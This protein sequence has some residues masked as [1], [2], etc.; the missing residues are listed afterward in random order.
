[1]LFANF[2]Y[3]QITNQLQNGGFEN[4]QSPWSGWSGNIQLTDANPYAGNY[5]ARFL[6]SGTLEQ[7]PVTVETGKTYKMSV[8][9]R[10]NSMSGNDW[11]GIRFSA[12]EYNWSEWHSSEFFTNGNRPVGQ[13][14]QEIITF[15]PSTTQIRAQIG[16]FG[17]SG[18]VPDFSFDEVFLFEEVVANEPP[19]IESFTLNTSSGTVPFTVTGEIVA[20]D[21]DGAITNYIIETGDGAVYAG[22]ATFSHVYRI[23]G[24]YSLLVTVVDDNGATATTS[25]AITAI[26]TNNHSIIITQPIA[27]T[28]GIYNTSQNT[29]T[30]EGNRQNGTG[31]IF[32]LNNR[33]MQSGFATVTSNSFIIPDMLLEVGI[34]HIQVQS[35]RSDGNFVTDDIHVNYVPESFNG[36]QIANL[37]VS[38]TAVKQYER[39]DVTFSLQTIADNLFFPF[40]TL[41][42]NNLQSGSG[43]SVDMEFSNGAI[44]KVQPAFLNMDYSRENGQ[45]LPTGSY[46]WNVR[47]AFKETGTW[48][49]RIIAR[50]ASGVT[51]LAGP[52]FNVVP[53]TS[54]NG[55][56]RVS[57]NDNRYFEYDN[58]KPFFAMG[59]GTSASGPDE[60]DQEITVWHENGLNFGR[61]WLSSSAPF[62][63]PWS[64][65]ATHH[66]MENN[67]YMPPPLLTFNQKYGNGQFS[68]RIASP[69][70]ENQNTPAIFRGFWDGPATVEPLSAY[71]LI[72]RVKTVNVSGN[73]GLVLK[74]GGWLGTD[75]INPGVG[76]VLT[77][78]MKGDNQWSYL[79]GQI[80][81][82]PGQTTLGYIYLVLEDCTGEAFIEQLTLQKINPDGSL[83]QNILPKWNA[84]SHYYL[85]P[86]KSKNID[87]MID[88]ANR[89]GIHY[90]IVIHEKNDF[91]SNHID[92]FGYVSSSQGNFN[93]P[94]G[95]KLHRIYEYYWRHLV[96]RWGYATAVHS[97]E[98]V[99]EGAPASYFE[100]TDDL[101]DFF[102]NHT[103]YPRMVSTSFWSNWEPD[104]WENSNAS[105]ADV[106]AYVMTTGWIDDI[107]I[108]G[109]LY[110]REDLK[111]DAAAAVY[112]YSTTVGT[113]PQR[114]KPVVL[115]ETDLDM[116]GN[117]SPDT[118]LIQDTQGVWLHNFNWA[119]LNHGGMQSLI[120]D[121]ENIRN[122]NL[123]S[124][125]KTFQHFMEDIPLTTG[126]YQQIN[127]TSG[128]ENLR[129]WGQMQ[130]SGNAAHFWVQNRN[131][132]WRNVL[133]NGTPVPINGIITVN[134]LMAGGAVLE[135]WNPWSDSSEAE[136]IDTVWVNESGTLQITI[137]QLV[138]D[139][140]FKVRSLNPGGG[141]VLANNWPQFQQNAARTGRTTLSV[142]PPYRARWIWTGPELTLRN[143]ESEPGWPDDLTT[144]D[145]YTYP[146]PDTIGFTIAGTVQAIVQGSRLYFAT[147]EGDAYA[148]NIHD[149]STLWSAD[150]HGGTLVSAAVLDDIVVFA[151]VNGIVYAF[152]TLTGVQQWNYN[153]KGAITTAPC[154]SGNNLLIA[155]HKGIVLHISAAGNVLWQQQLPA[156]VVGGIAA[157]GNSVYV[158]CENMHV[159]ALNLTNGSIRASQEVRGQSFRLCHPV[160]Y[161]GQLFVTS[162][163]VPMVGSEYIME[164][165]MASSNNLEEE[166]A[167]IRLWLQGNNNGGTWPNAS[168]DWQHIFALDA[169]TL[170]NLFLIPAGPVEGVGMPAPSVVIDNTGRVL[171]WWKTR[172][173]FLTTQGPAFGTN[174]T[175]DI[176]GI[177][178]LN[179]NRV[180]INNG[181]LSG[182]WPLET[183]NLY[184][185][186][187]GGDYLWMRQNFRGTQVINLSNSQHVLAQVTT[188]YND[189]GDFGNAHICYRNTNLNNGIHD[190]PYILP[191]SRTMGRN[192]PAIAGSYV[193]LTEEFAIVA[194]ENY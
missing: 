100:L 157:V 68:Y 64:S 5:A 84:N 2:S 191:Q 146:I 36:P 42:P 179:G 194:I 38:K 172:F 19:V 23:Q 46:E 26:G 124:R 168:A 115:G 24:S 6:T 58:G 182:M 61:F 83:Q 86:I 17:G 95:S 25:Q 185:L 35:Y 37:Q 94:Q 91:I 107:T 183:D 193:F 30:L 106:H 43:V 136:S 162:V 21:P 90:K 147:M 126:Q 127:A 10:I 144:R 119:H 189:G 66:P 29:V 65:W 113:H 163:T 145:G 132:T 133:L 88:T 69:A 123:W 175:L 161:N 78:Y 181:Q 44:V 8:W 139:M 128:N 1:L 105:Y 87:Y 47:M 18:W 159:Y 41:M 171:R 176:A 49:S 156:P 81:T 138:R 93:Q 70:I 59:H 15:T 48:T 155:N 173:P 129:V 92:N 53:D 73:G 85:D 40:D 165:V 143:Q 80:E 74:T 164:E 96:A 45:L 32:W 11:G 9:I 67:G 151:G 82:G 39:T 192:G 33:S 160:V 141:S 178:P 63:D 14:F 135:T 28:E 97:W 140:A 137:N 118:L 104:F 4:G 108:D 153:T 55:Y 112:A 101:A 103:P 116:P 31:T 89:A 158:P 51:E 20:S 177:N 190:V 79:T 142:A 170:E 184:G 57:A 56:I 186:T 60:T 110:N 52:V 120:W 7:S 77:S 167:N 98:L 187:V 154:V 72:A 22:S 152:D 149:G 174:Y 27:N 16:F 76:T 114:N 34:N 134:G 102:T 75:V 99:N 111:N 122:N 50:D 121:S 3:A 12:I 62:S 148:L 130:A 131:H 71:R 166:E 117:Q 109:Q 180:P 169:V 188:R 54:N 150:V 13:W 125:Y